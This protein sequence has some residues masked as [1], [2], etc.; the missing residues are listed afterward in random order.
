[1]RR[2]PQHPRT[3]I[4]LQRQA[5][6]ALVGT[7]AGRVG[8]EWTTGR[9]GCFAG[10]KCETQ[11]RRDPRYPSRLAGKP[12]VVSTAPVHIAEAAAELTP[13]G[14]APVCLHGWNQ[15]SHLRPRGQ[16]NRG[17]QIFA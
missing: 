9:L 16:A 14:R 7:D 2:G 11:E 1:E 10:R 12:E 3:S 6:V 15:R 8:C 5:E 4:L 17:E 13:T